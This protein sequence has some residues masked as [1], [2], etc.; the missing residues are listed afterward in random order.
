VVGVQA[1]SSFDN[2]VEGKVEIENALVRRA[3]SFDEPIDVYSLDNIVAHYVFMGDQNEKMREQWARQCFPHLRT[4]PLS[5][6]SAAAVSRAQTDFDVLVVS[7]YDVPRSMKFL[8]ENYAA[9]R[10]MPKIALVEE[11]RATKRAKLLLAGYDDVFD[12]SRMRVEE[13]IARICAMRARFAKAQASIEEVE[14]TSRTLA[15]VAYV[16]RLSKRERMI[17][18]ELISAPNRFCSYE[19]LRSLISEWGEEISNN[20]LKVIISN[21]RAKLKPG[22]AVVA[23]MNAGY[24]LSYST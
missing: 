7:G 24:A 16:Q 13:G 2:S 8:K 9:V 22:V 21:M 23:R 6:D 15:Q 18:L 20:N 17:L 11:S 3:F 14:N 10:S 5:I 12:I 1:R 19:L 4:F